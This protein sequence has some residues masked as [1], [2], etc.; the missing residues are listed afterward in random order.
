MNH[1]SPRKNTFDVS[2]TRAILT[3]DTS[4]KVDNIWIRHSIVFIKW[5]WGISSSHIV[6][7]RSHLLFFA[8]LLRY[9]LCFPALVN[10]LKG[11]RRRT[12]VSIWSLNSFLGHERRKLSDR[13]SVLWTYVHPSRSTG[14][15]L[16]LEIPWKL[17]HSRREFNFRIQNNISC[18]L[19]RL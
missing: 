19:C 9:P 2:Q 18:K 6:S 12:R 3:H 13:I 17:A 1:A 16:D 7:K 5:H 10:V 14:W 8:S 11:P 4:R 15:V